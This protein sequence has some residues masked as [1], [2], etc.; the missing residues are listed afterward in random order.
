MIVIL[1]NRRVVDSKS[2]QLRQW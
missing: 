2:W 1:R